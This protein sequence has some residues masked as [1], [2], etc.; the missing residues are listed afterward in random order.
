MV[1]NQK[2]LEAVFLTPTI[3]DHECLLVGKKGVHFNVILT[4][5]HCSAP[6]HFFR[7]SRPTPRS[8]RARSARLMRSRRALSCW[9]AMA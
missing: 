4:E 9:M 7:S 1:T 6:N 2:E 3:S 8:L 5:N